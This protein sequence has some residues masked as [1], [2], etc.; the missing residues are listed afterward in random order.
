R[1]KLAQGIWK[2]LDGSFRGK[3]FNTTIRRNSRLQQAVEAGKPITVFDPQSAGYK[4]YMALAKELLSLSLPP[5]EPVARTA[6]ILKKNLWR[7]L[8]PQATAQTLVDELAKETVIMAEKA[9][10]MTE[11]KKE[12]APSLPSVALAEP[13]RGGEADPSPVIA[14]PPKA[15]EAISG[16]GTGS[17]I[18]KS[19]IATPAE[20]DRRARNDVL[21]GASSQAETESQEEALPVLQE[22]EPEEAE[23]V[24][25][26]GEEEGKESGAIDRVYEEIRSLPE[27]QAEGQRLRPE[28]AEASSKREISVEESSPNGEALAEVVFSYSAPSA[29]KVEIIA[30]FT[31][32]QPLP[33]NPPPG[34]QGVWIKIFHLVKGA[35]HYKFLVDGKKTIDLKNPRFVMC[36]QGG[37]VSVIEL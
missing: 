20:K 31:N 3:V 17:A 25:V 14:S 15:D 13:V 27:E 26:P 18:S 35:Y 8:T 23:P 10:E 34:P 11:M 12:S 16:L 5:A 37:I 4:D 30:D 2:K 7:G 21:L 6:P 1:T 29:R 32:W 36:P 19:E 24:K 22:G 9:S 28:E 33:L